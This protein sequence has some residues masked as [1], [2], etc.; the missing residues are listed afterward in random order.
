M[1]AAGYLLLVCAVL[2]GGGSVHAQSIGS[3]EYVA[4]DAKVLRPEGQGRSAVRGDA[5]QSGETVETGSGRMHLRMVDGAYISLAPGTVLRFDEYR[6]SG[7][8][9]GKES[10]LMNLVKG[11]M[12]TI[13]GLIGRR[14]RDRYQLQTAVATIGIRGTEFA[15]TYG[16]SITVN[17]GGGEVSVCNDGGCLNLGSGQTGYVR[18]RLARPVLTQR[19]VVLPPPPVSAEVAGFRR[20]EDR[21]PSGQSEILAGPVEAAQQAITPPVVTP[22]QVVTPPP[23]VTPPIVPLTSGSYGLSSYISRADGAI[24]AGLLGGPIVFDTAGAMISYT[25]CCGFSYTGGIAA[26]FGADGIL[27]WGRWTGGNSTHPSVSGAIAIHH[28]VTGLNTPPSVLNTLV[29]TYASFASTAPTA[30]SGGVITAGTANSAT[31]TLNI[32]FPAG[33][34]GYTLSVPVAGFTFSLNGTATFVNNSVNSG[35]RRFL[36][37]GTITSTG[38]GCT[39]SCTGQIPFGPNVMGLVF[40]ASGERAN[41]NY[42]FSSPAAG[43]VSGAVMFK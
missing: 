19:T 39:P 18:D 22:P 27:A 33:T 5:I 30:L 31:G 38:S 42:G 40:G 10:A 23:P 13:T 26:D 1:R 7:A 2:V 15:V 24:A 29:R 34:A 9:D 41:L 32:N 20:S 12:R 36:G 6:Y 25:D 14:N 4:G 3:I 16:N 28:Y 17:V 37:G 35:D 43:Q 21:N 8:Q 11:G